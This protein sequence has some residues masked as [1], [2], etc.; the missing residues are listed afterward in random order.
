M[1]TYANAAIDALAAAVAAPYGPLTRVTDLTTLP[2]PNDRALM[3]FTD[4]AGHTLFMR[5]EELTDADRL[6]ELLAEANSPSY[7][8]HEVLTEL[9]DILVDVPLA[10]DG[11]YTDSEVRQVF[12]RLQ[13]LDFVRNYL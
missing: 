10:G 8:V 3:E 5:Y 13:A 7:L 12:E 2:T 9:T 6:L 4:A 1:P 11:Q